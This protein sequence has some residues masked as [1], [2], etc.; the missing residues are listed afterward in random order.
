MYDR[1]KWF[2]ATL[3]AA[4]VIGFLGIFDAEAQGQGAERGKAELTLDG[5]K[6]TITFGRPSTEG[7]GY[8]SMEAGVPDGT[9]WRM[10]SNQATKIETEGDLKFGDT[11]IKAG[12][13]SLVAKRKGDKW[14]LLFHPNADRWGIPVPKDGYIAE[15]ELKT[16]KPKEPVKLL[17]LK[18]EKTD[19]GGEFTLAWGDEQGK[20]K[21]TLG[22]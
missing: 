3:T 5:K 2:T 13:Y 9:L 1:R 15:V 18:L 4:L 22:E 14:N 6:I 21:F 16:S 12:T 19:D 17:T 11:V 10:G 8:K 7:A 20:A